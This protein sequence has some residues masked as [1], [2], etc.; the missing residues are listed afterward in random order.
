[1]E[2]LILQGIEGS[3]PITQT[4]D[5]EFLYQFQNAVLL[6]LLESGT[7][8]DTQYRHAE[9]QLRRSFMQFSR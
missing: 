5:P 6:A 1:M 9:A 8:K 7:L 2:H 4:T 3:H